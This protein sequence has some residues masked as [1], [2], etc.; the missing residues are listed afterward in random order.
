MASVDGSKSALV[1]SDEI[2]CCGSCSNRGSDKEAKSYCNECQEY[3]CNPCAESHK[4]LKLTRSHQL[5]PVTDVSR[6]I[7]QDSF[8]SCLVLCDCSQNIGVSVY[9][10]DHN[11]VICLSCQTVKHRKLSNRIS[12]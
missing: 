12:H 2:H 6:P 11:D 10:E 5:L 9:C 8:V 3:L 1:T 4:G 7:S